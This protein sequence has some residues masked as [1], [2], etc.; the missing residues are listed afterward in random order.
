V[1]LAELV[2][3][4]FFALLFGVVGVVLWCTARDLAEG[5]RRLRDGEVSRSA[6]DRS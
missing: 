5:A 4:A 6:D 3:T 1:D 2:G